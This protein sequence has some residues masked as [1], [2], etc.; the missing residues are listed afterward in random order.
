MS[1]I[2]KYKLFESK[3]NE[4]IAKVKAD[5]YYQDMYKEFDLLPYM[6]DK[7]T[8]VLADN[9]PDI[10]AYARL[11]TNKIKIFLG[12]KVYHNS[13]FFK[14]NS[15]TDTLETGVSSDQLQMMLAMLAM[16]IMSSVWTFNYDNYLYP[17]KVFQ[18]LNQDELQ[19]IADNSGLTVEDIKDTLFKD[20]SN[21]YHVLKSLLEIKP[22]HV[23]HLK[24]LPN[25]I[26]EDDETKQA[27]LDLMKDSPMLL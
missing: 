11:D 5:E 19:H 10:V 2:T 22:Q 6:S 15:E 16:G 4:F 3:D 14:L 13:T 7:D 18:N 21:K 24:Y 26:D 8:F 20:A 27:Y 1:L 25:S 17:N 9:V 23:A 12:D